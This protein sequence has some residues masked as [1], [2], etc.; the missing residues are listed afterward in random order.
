MVTTSIIL[1]AAQSL[2]S[3]DCSENL[4]EA[5]CLG[6]TVT[7]KVGKAHL[8][9]RTKRRMRAAAGEVFPQLGRPGIDYVL[10]GRYNTAEVDFAK[11]TGD[12]RQAVKRINK[13]FRK[14]VVVASLAEEEP[15]YEKTADSA[16]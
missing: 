6:F 16:D 15:V 5:C 4:E 14:E 13:F 8:R 1:Q 7:K 2:S 10:I 11:L 9:N 12:M 3:V